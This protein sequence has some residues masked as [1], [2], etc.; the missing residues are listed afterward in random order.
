M[1]AAIFVGFVEVKFPEGGDKLQYIFFSEVFNKN[2]RS[3]ML[4][5]VEP[6]TLDCAEPDFFTLNLFMLPW[7]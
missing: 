6:F 7:L 3:C 5:D 1:Y 2:T 4:Q